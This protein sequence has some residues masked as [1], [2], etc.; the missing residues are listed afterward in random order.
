MTNNSGIKPVDLK[1]LV[2]P[3]KVEAKTAGGIFLPD[4]EIERK[5]WAAQKA[6]II[7]VGKSCFAEWIEKPQPGDRVVLAQYPGSKFQGEDG[8][9][10]WIIND[11]DIIGLLE[12]TT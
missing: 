10:Y 5:Q 12:K 9:M 7:D 11:D 1:L 3:D 4:A 8:E 2:L 6:T